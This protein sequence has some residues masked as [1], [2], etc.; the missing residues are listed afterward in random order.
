MGA[1]KHTLYAQTACWS[2]HVNIKL[3]TQV[4]V[5]NPDKPLPGAPGRPFSN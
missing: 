2:R 1:K 5:I 4:H 3:H